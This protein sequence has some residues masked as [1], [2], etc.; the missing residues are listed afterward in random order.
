MY[1]FNV[2][3][4]EHSIIENAKQLKVYEHSV[5]SYIIYRNALIQLFLCQSDTSDFL[6]PNL[7]FIYFIKVK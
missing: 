7:I 6:F 5:R 4:V 1:L 2:F 3:T